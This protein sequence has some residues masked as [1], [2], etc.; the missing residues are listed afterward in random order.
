MEIFQVVT[1]KLNRTGSVFFLHI[2]T[3]EMTKQ[4]MIKIKR[5]MG[6]EMCLTCLLVLEGKHCVFY[7]EK[8]ISTYIWFV[9]KNPQGI[10]NLLSVQLLSGIIC[11]CYVKKG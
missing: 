5:F 8:Y 10:L 3:T 2:Y 6:K 1:F 9:L 4:V 7:E 11:C